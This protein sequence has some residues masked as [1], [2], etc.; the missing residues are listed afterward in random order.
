MITSISVII[1]FDNDL[2]SDVSMS[3]PKIRETI[4]PSAIIKRTARYTGEITIHNYL[5]ISYLTKI[6]LQLRQDNRNI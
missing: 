5:N 1:G 2:L 6:C 4:H 3:L